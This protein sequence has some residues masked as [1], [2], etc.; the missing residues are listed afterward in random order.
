MKHIKIIKAWLD[1]KTIQHKS[2]IGGWADLTPASNFSRIPYLFAD[3]NKYRIAPEKKKFRVWQ[4]KHGELCVIT[5][6][7]YDL[8]ERAL[9][10]KRWITGEIEYE[11]D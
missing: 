6:T 4:T 3:K 10:F 7:H 11:S 8:V 5:N 1:G 9:S 2:S